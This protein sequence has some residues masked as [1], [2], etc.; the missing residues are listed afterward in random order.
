MKMNATDYQL[1]KATIER[2][3]VQGKVNLAEESKRYK[4][5]GLS[6]KRFRWDLLRF[7]GVKIGNSAGTPGPFNLYDYLDNTHIDTALKAIVKELMH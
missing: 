2:K 6:D 4:E 1:L 5:Q 7:A 3:L